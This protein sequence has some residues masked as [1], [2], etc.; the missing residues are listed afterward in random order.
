MC[1]CGVDGLTDMLRRVA[2]R[3]ICLPGARIMRV[4]NACC[5]RVLDIQVCSNVHI[6]T[7]KTN[8]GTRAFS[9]GAP[10]L[11]NSLPVSFMFAGN[12]T[13]F[14]HKLKTHL[15]QLAYPH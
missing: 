14:R 11:W 2:E 9:V 12:I 10:T 8:V 7:M 6:T 5:G 15:L 4:S 13:T 3:N 1:E